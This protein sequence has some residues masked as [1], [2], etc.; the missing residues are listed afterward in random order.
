MYVLSTPQSSGDL[1]KSHSQQSQH[2]NLGCLTP[3]CLLSLCNYFYPNQC[4]SKS[5][6]GHHFHGCIL[7]HCQSFKL[8]PVFSNS[9]NSAQHTWAKSLLHTFPNTSF[10]QIPR[11]RSTGPK[12]MNVLRL[13]I[14]LTTCF[15]ERL[16]QFTLPSS[17]G[18]SATVKAD[19]LQGLTQ[20]RASHNQ[21]RPDEHPPGLMGE[22]HLLSCFL[23][24]SMIIETIHYKAVPDFM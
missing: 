1:P 16:H 11:S 21:A 6:R 17:R 12:G 4:C 10:G 9:Y 13:L 15:S 18:N 24:T 2:S 14:Y 3:G 7:L 22:S 19:N 23:H 5:F 20:T 8:F